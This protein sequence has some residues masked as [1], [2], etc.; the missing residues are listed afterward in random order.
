MTQAE[1]SA[2]DLD[3][4]P[5]NELSDDEIIQFFADNPDFFQRYP[6][7]LDTLSIPHENGTAI[8]LVERQITLLREKNTDLATQLNSL[9]AVA[10]DNNQTQQQIHQMTLE[11]L[12][13]PDAHAALE[14][15]TAALAKDFK[16]EHV[17]IR[18]LADKSHPLK[19]I[20]P[21]YVLTSHSARETLDGLTPTNEPRCGRFKES[22]LKRLFGGQADV[23]AS[24][25]IVPMRKQT[26]HAVIA[27]G[28]ENEHR[29]N[30]GMDTL[31]LK[32]LGDL[33]AAALQRFID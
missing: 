7:I 8:S 13:A 9:L 10:H 25:V 20:D 26:L 22:Q 21:A 29:F 31:Y 19:N 28:S 16:V 32:R 33:I 5:Q 15:L 11:V 4:Y 1:Q 14:Q 30:P 18:L 6:D 27:L 24:A 17:A 12:A 2:S 3:S 23:V